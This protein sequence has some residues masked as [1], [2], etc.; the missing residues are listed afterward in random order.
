[1]Y[2]HNI[3]LKGIVRY[4]Y[5]KMGKAIKDYQM[6]E[7]KD[8]ILVVVSRFPFSLALLELFMMR[9]KRIPI[10]FEIFACFVSAPF[11]KINQIKLE[12]YIKFLKV[13]FIWHRLDISLNN[14]ERKLWC[15][16]QA[17]ELFFEIVQENRCNKIAL[18]DC[19]DDV[20]E[21]ILASFLFEGKI[22]TNKPKIDLPSF[23]I[24]R[25]LCY[26]SKKDLIDFSKKINI[27]YLDYE[28]LL[29]P[30]PYKKICKEIIIKIEERCPFVKKN[31]FRALGRIREDYLL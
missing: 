22:E 15:I 29:K 20:A 16:P 13:N 10:E 14:E 31:I 12:K 7:N 27:P 3:K 24:I 6:L 5:K 26:V 9:K 8:K 25:P 2:S 19:L 30:D 18:D 4:I 21:E 11:M 1:M 17:R 23:S 28:S